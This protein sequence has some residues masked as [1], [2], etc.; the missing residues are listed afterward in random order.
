M[1][2][3]LNLSDGWEQSPPMPCIPD[4]LRRAG[5]QESDKIESIDVTVSRD[6]PVQKIDVVVDVE[7]T[8]P[9]PEDIIDTIRKLT[10]KRDKLDDAIVGLKDQLIAM[11]KKL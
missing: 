11:V 4:F 7:D 6:N 10:A 9:T 2:G 5:V 3:D 8:P 1:S